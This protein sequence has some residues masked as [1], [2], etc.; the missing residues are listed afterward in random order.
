MELM[1]RLET[2]HQLD[3]AVDIVIE[4]EPRFHAA[5]RSHGYPRLRRMRPGLASL[6]R[7]VTDQLISLKAGEAIWARIACSIDPAD[8]RSL[9]VMPEQDLIRLGLSGGKA[10]TFQATARAIM[11]GNIDF[12]ALEQAPDRE[13]LAC[14]QS[15]KGIGPW[16]ADIYLMMAMG[17]ADA[18]PRGDLALQVAAQSLLGLESRPAPREMERLS[19]PWQ[20]QRAAA[21]HL[22][23]S[24]YRGIKGM[25]QAAP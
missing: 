6:L 9:A 23:W 19:A 2:Q 18:W 15:I 4:R 12:D 24:H 22:L 14:L 17:R 16:T 8:A 5:V 11:D 13:V 20:P 21:A 7:I 10:R 25:K 3:A 1:T